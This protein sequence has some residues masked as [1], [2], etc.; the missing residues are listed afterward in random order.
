MPSVTSSR[1]G[2]VFVASPAHRPALSEVE[3]QAELNLTRAVGGGRPPEA[4]SGVG[5]QCRRVLLGSCR[6]ARLSTLKP[7]TII[8]RLDALAE[9]EPAAQPQVE[10]GVV[11]TAPGVPAHARGPVVDVRVVVAVIARQDVEREPRAVLEDVAQLETRE[12]PAEDGLGAPG[13]PGP[14][15]SR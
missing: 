8:S 2:P 12:R 15:T 10:R 6:F 13:W 14:R 5:P 4:C 7:S 3:P 11:E 1:A 9:A